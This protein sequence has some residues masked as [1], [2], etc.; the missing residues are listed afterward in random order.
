MSQ[1]GSFGIA[2][3]RM[4]AKP[5]R[6]FG[7]MIGENN[8][9]KTSFLGSNPAALIVNMDLSSTPVPSLDAPPPPCQL[10]PGINTEGQCIDFDHKPMVL[11]G[12]AID[13]L[14]VRL[15][16][17]ATKNQPR[18]ETIVFDS[19]GAWINL[20]KAQ[21]LLH[22]KKDSWD[23]GHGEAMWE[24]LYNKILSTMNEL[25]AAGYGVWIIAHITFEY[26]DD[27]TAGGLKKKH[28]SLTTP[29]G[30]F[31]RF[32]GMFEVALELQKTYTIKVSDV[33]RTTKMADG[34]TVQMPDKVEER[35]P[36]FVLIGESPTMQS[37]YKRRVAFPARIELPA[38]GSWDKFTKMYMDVAVPTATPK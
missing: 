17:A 11:T 21:T 24:Y 29:P 13:G 36:L 37:L 27:G 14:K 19:A 8:T 2:N 35:I 16:E 3:Q 22:F 38:Q 9:G 1:Y 31:K 12:E 33:V 5:G 23:A 6:V 26:I 4:V 25:R 15:I 32:Y 28:Y 30:F 34:S 18:P 20:L 7:I 10:W